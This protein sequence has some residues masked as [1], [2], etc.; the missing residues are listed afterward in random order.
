MVRATFRTLS[1][2][3]TTR[4]KKSPRILIVTIE[5]RVK[6]TVCPADARNRSSEKSL[7]KLPSPAKILGFR[8]SPSQEKNEYTMPMQ[9]GMSTTVAKIKSRGAVKKTYQPVFR[10]FFI[11]LSF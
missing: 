2:V 7:L 1:P 10:I 6:I 4:A 5:S 8:G 3:V 11:S 9:K